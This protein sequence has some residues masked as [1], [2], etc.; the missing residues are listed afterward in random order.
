MA[1]EQPAGASPVWHQRRGMRQ[2]VKFCIVGTLNTAVD[3]TVLN[4]ALIGFGYTHF[5]VH[6]GGRDWAL[7]AQAAAATAH[8]VSSTNGFIWN[9]IWTFRGRG[10]VHHEYAR[11]FTVYTVGLG[12]RL[13]MTTI[14]ISIQDR[15]FHIPPHSVLAANISQLVAIPIVVFWNFFMFRHWVFQQVAGPRK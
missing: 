9:R 15:I 5:I 2:F 12:L 14:L 3:F 8:V 10:L 4:I 11:G 6:L 13:A 1:A 7:G